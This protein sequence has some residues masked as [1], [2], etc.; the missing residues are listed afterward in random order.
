MV[1]KYSEEPLLAL[2][3]RSHDCSVRG[4]I[5]QH[6]IIYLIFQTRSLR[7]WERFNRPSKVTLR[8]VF[9]TSRCFIC[10]SARLRCVEG[11][12]C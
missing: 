12:I 9:I 2:K 3:S 8:Y 5:N 6:H 4:F 7:G 1:E 10:L 11:N